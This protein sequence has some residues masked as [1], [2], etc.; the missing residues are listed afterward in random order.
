MRLVIFFFSLFVTVCIAVTFREKSI[1]QGCLAFA[2]K[3][4]PIKLL[5]N[6]TGRESFEV[7]SSVTQQSCAFTVAA[8]FSVLAQEKLKN[9]SDNHEKDQTRRRSSRLSSG[10]SHEIL[11]T[12]HV[13]TSAEVQTLKGT[14]SN[15]KESEKGKQLPDVL[16]IYGAVQVLV[17]ASATLTFVTCS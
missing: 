7:G 10:V 8:D 15:P 9:S 17:V 2:V 12:D 1:H 13:T 3:L 5:Q 14:E 11:N 6:V 4:S 16:W